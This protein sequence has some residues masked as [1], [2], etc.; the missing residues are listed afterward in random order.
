MNIKKP[1]TPQNIFESQKSLFVSHKSVIPPT[2]H[3]QVIIL[4][5]KFECDD[6]KE[7][8]IF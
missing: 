8:A 6:T 3:Q 1:K 4:Q 7:T 2:Q 5:Y